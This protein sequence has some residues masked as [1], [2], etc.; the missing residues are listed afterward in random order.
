LEGDYHWKGV[1]QLKVPLILLPLFPCVW[2]AQHALVH[3]L[4]SCVYVCVWLAQHA[5]VHQLASCVYVCVVGAMCKRT[6]R[7]TF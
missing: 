1:N 5:L 6:C 3:Q 2:L 7:M 4:A